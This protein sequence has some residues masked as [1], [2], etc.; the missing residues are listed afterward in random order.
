MDQCCF[1]T[2]KNLIIHNYRAVG[3]LSDSLRIGV[4]LNSGVWALD[5]LFITIFSN[6]GHLVL[7]LNI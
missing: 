2:S 5:F 1:I 7:A 4:L 6:N 3:Q